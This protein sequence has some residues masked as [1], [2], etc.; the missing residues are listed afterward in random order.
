MKPNDARR[1]IERYLAAYNSFDSDGMMALIHS[2]VQFKNISDGRV[3]DSASGIAAFRELAE[4]SKKLFSFRKQM[5]RGFSANEDRVSIEIDFEGMLACDLP[6]GRRGETIRLKGRSE[7]SFR[8]GKIS[9]LA[10]IS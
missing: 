9:E 7:F 5:I 1:L 3:T 4:R 2:D 10:D 6:V 8:D